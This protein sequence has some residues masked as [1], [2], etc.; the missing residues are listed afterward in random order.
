MKR[1]ALLD[2]L[3]T[4]RARYDQAWARTSVDLAIQVCWRARPLAGAAQRVHRAPVSRAPACRSSEPGCSAACDGQCEPI[5][6]ETRRHACQG[7]LADLL[8][9]SQTPRWTA[10]PDA[11]GGLPAVTWCAGLAAA[12][13]C[14]AAGLA[15][16]AS[17]VM[18][19]LWKP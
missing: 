18:W 10:V 12:P 2:C 16:L 5:G 9:F 13:V 17:Y 7:A 15:V 11:A 1:E 3:A 19:R 4:A 8:S 6:Q 14:T